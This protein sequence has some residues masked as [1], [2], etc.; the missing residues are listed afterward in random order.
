MRK[1]ATTAKTDQLGSL[2]LLAAE[3]GIDD[4]V[5]LT[6]NM[7][8]ARIE[9]LLG[10]RTQLESV[11]WYV[12]S[13]LRHVLQMQWKAPAQ[14]GISTE[15][16]YALAEACLANP[17]FSL[18]IK[19]VLKGDACKYQ[20][21]EFRR[22]RNPVRRILANTTVAF[23]CAEKILRDAQLINF[24]EPLQLEPKLQ[25]AE[26]GQHQ[27]AAAAEITTASLRRASRRGF[28]SDAVIAEATA[29]FENTAAQSAVTPLHAGL[30]PQE[31]AELEQALMQQA[32]P[33]GAKHARQVFGSDE[34]RSW[35]LGLLAGFGVF[36]V[37]LLLLS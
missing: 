11:R 25:A 34:S 17:D 15:Q 35:L 37:I 18:S 3:L 23:H 19:T 21:V 5:G 7:L 4:T 27:S 32:V 1:L 26:S 10:D 24:V 36:G 16:Q 9:M 12:L 14:S 29:H 22:T 8:I 28:V 6:A 31:Y 30:T 33:S 2:L 20:L 13:V